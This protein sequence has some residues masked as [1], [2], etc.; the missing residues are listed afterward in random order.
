MGTETDR[1]DAPRALR[2]IVWAIGQVGFP[3]VVAG[4]L[5]W[6]IGPKLDQIVRLL[7]LLISLHK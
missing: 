1:T 3:M 2:W 6:A 7:E 4:Y 5:L